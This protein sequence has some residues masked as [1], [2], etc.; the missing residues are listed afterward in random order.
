VQ[1]IRFNV[2]E[3]GANSG[4]LRE[5]IPHHNAVRNK[6]KRHIKTLEFRYRVKTDE[7]PK[8]EIGRLTLELAGIAEQW[9]FLPVLKY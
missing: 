7:K 4:R 2:T 6:L 5:R 9:E 8:A 1:L 3:K